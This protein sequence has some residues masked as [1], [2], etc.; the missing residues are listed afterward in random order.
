[1]GVVKTVRNTPNADEDV[2]SRISP[3]RKLGRNVFHFCG[4]VTN[5]YAH[6]E[7]F[8]PNMF[9]PRGKETT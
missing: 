2:T 6:M 8:M 5:H 1:M 4:T 3:L 7:R 9:A